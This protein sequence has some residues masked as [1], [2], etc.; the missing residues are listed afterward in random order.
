[1][2]K[3]LLILYHIGSLFFGV[4]EMGRPLPPPFWDDLDAVEPL[5]LLTFHYNASLRVVVLDIHSWFWFEVVV[6][7]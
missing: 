7:K 6:P 3:W 4:I 2:T 1:M 5:V